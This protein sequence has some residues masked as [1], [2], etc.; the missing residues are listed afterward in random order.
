MSSVLTLKEPHACLDWVAVKKRLYAPHG[1]VMLFRTLHTK[2]FYLGLGEINTDQSFLFT[3][4]LC[5]I[6]KVALFRQQLTLTLTMLA[7]CL[8]AALRY[9]LLAS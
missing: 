3:V 2:S 8:I 9:S 4:L 5:G 1:R 6:K 7:S